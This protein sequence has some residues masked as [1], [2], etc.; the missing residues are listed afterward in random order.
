MPVTKFGRYFTS[1]AA[2]A[3]MIDK[4]VEDHYEGVRRAVDGEQQA[5]PV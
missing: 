2:V 3:A 4:G 1:V 5:E